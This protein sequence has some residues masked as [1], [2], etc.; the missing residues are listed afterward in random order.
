MDNNNYE[1]MTVSS[2]KNLARKKGLRGYYRL[3]KSELIKKL[4]EPSPTTEPT[5]EEL[6]QQ[7]REKGIWGY[8]RLNKAELL[9]RLRTF[10]DQILDR[11][12]DVR[13][14]N[15][16]FLTPTPYILPQATPTTSS[17][18]NAVKNLIDY[19]N[20][21]KE[22]PKSVSPNPKKLLEKIES[23]Y[24]L[25]K[26]FE[27][28]DSNSAL[29]KFAKVYTIN[30]IEGYDARSFLQDARQNIT[31]VLRNNRRTK[32]KLILKCGKAN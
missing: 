2:L 8:S 12:I 31:S 4:R 18:S 15:V 9:Q 1:Q 11:D 10:G 23:I 32:V 29:R 14:T 25:R 21:V 22:T 16:S 24:K 3:N 6:R 30:G 28:R 5:R 27:V 19:L 17:S 7:A 13:M 20:N 26:L